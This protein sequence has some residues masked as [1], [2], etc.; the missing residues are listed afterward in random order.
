M[1][2]RCN[3]KNL[4]RR[5]KKS[6]RSATQGSYIFSEDVQYGNIMI[7]L[8]SQIT[9]QG[10]KRETTIEKKERNTKRPGLNLRLSLHSEEA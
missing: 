1:Y 9:D 2:S 6:K 10:R 7:R 4:A 8:Y 5:E 3:A